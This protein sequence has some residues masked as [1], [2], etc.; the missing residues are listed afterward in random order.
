[1]V[2][3]FTPSAELEEAV[4]RAMAVPE[5]APAFVDRLAERLAER[6]HRRPGLVARRRWVW[7]LG[8]LLILLLAGAAIGPANIVAAMQR[9]LGYIPGVGL[10]DDSGGLR[11]LAAPVTL[12]REGIT[13]TVSQAV[14]D[15]HQTVVLYQVDGIPPEALV[16]RVGEGEEMPPFCGAMPELRLSDTAGPGLIGGSGGGGRGYER[17]T[18][19]GTAEGHGWSS[20][21][22]WRVVYEAIPPD[23][24]EALFF[25]PC[26][27]D[28]APG[29]APESWELTLH[30]IP[31][32]PEVTVFPVFQVTPPPE[33]SS[34]P[35]EAEEAGLVLDQVIETE[36]SYILI[37]TFR[38]GLSIPGGMVMGFLDLDITTENGQSWIF[39]PAE[40]LD[41]AQS[42]PGVVP[43]AFEIMKGYPTPPLTLRVDSVDVELSADAMIEFDTGPDPEP[44]QEWILNR[45]IEV[46]GRRVTLLSVTLHEGPRENGYEFFF[47]ADADIYMVRVEDL[48]HMVAGGY[49][50][51]WEGEFSDGL[52]YEGTVPSGSLTFHISAIGLRVA[53]PWTL[54]WEPPAEGAGGTPVSLPEPCFTAEV[55][56]QALESPM[57][58][59]A[60]LEGRI[61]AYGTIVDDGGALSPE[62]AGVFVVDLM[63]GERQVLGPGTW[64]ALSPN[65]SRAVYSG[66]DALHIVDLET[67]EDRPLPGTT[68][69]DFRPRWSPDGSEI[70]FVHGDDRNL[71][72]VHTDGSGPQQVTEG[73]EYELLVDWSPD[74]GS[75]LFGAPGPEGIVLR[76]VDRLT[77]EA[78][79]VLTFDGKDASAA[80]SPDGRRLAVLARVAGMDYGL[81][82][83]SI[84]GSESRLLAQLDGWTISDPVWS[85]DGEWL[86]LTV[87]GYDGAEATLHPV[88]LSPTTCEV[89][90]VVGIEGYIL[91]WS[92][93]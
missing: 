42:Q 41:L 18:A 19:A 34:A 40:D 53:G 51:G 32:P 85:P 75:L 55:W 30:F 57:A 66:Q 10:V 58:L 26:I 78:T 3:E 37:G 35:P 24:S 92:A 14:L 5:A 22:E 79:D 36:E 50:G 93:P 47:R 12:E 76:F 63:T 33:T 46:A 38:Q 61:I 2:A 56:E 29:A 11:V 87:T 48:E 23:V 52:V 80:L 70:A 77:G 7:A 43:W 59:P 15:A 69:A 9:L 84:D 54:T 21:Y 73:P 64:P 88:L 65:G 16:Q 1:M 83:D 44:G 74:G 89:F 82:L 13:V 45:E 4:R 17:V 86:M 49:G 8:L 91:D 20:G 6:A 71:Y 72:V 39:W 62:N 28:T 90:P 25:M 67:G 81:F 27:H 60:G 68:P 31:A